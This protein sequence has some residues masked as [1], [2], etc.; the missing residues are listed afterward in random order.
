MGR[1]AGYQID[2]STEYWGFTL[3]T[4]PD[5]VNYGDEDRRDEYGNL[6]WVYFYYNDILKMANTETT[7]PLDVVVNKSNLQNDGRIG[8]DT[9]EYVYFVTEETV[10]GY[11]DAVYSNPSVSS[12][13]G[14]TAWIP[15]TEYAL[16]NGRII[17]RPED[18]FELPSTG[19][20]GTALFRLTGIIITGLAG[21]ALAMRKRRRRRGA[22]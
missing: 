3:T 14:E 10:N 22:V 16:N 5:E 8:D 6:Q 12:A 13:E 21:A 15:S 19:G 1:S 4:D 7:E 18:S 9:G 2:S 11:R 17:N 20:P